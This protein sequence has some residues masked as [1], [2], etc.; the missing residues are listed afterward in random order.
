MGTNHCCCAG[1][2]TIS[3]FL[4]FKVVALPGQ[5]RDDAAVKSSTGSPIHETYRVRR[6]SAYDEA[7]LLQAKPTCIR[8]NDYGQ[9]W[10]DNISGPDSYRVR[11]QFCS[12]FRPRHG[13]EAV[14]V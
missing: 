7:R 13:H 6:R 10:R 1:C 14:L 8:K 5:R 12:V 3:N 11:G 2:P 4:T 9:T